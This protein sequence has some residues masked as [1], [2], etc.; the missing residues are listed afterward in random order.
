VSSPSSDPARA[1]ALTRI[2]DELAGVREAVAALAAENASL[3]ARLEQSET[4]R[5]DL[6]AQIEQVLEKLAGSRRA[7]RALQ[8]EQ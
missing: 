7:I 6:V 5:A 3:R 2:A 8:G 4:A 1:D